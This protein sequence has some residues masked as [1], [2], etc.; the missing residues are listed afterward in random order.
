MELRNILARHEGKTLE[1]KRDDTNGDSLARTAVAFANTAGGVIVIGVAD[2][3][4]EIVGVR[5]PLEA[6]E[7]VANLLAD[8]VAPRL[9]PD[10]EILPW[11]DT[12][13]V[14]VRVHPGPSKPYRVVGEGRK[15]G[16]Y[17]RVGSTNRLADQDLVQELTRVGQGGTFDEQPLGDLAAPDAID[18]AA[19][20]AAFEGIRTVRRR[21]LESLRLATE[22]QG[23][24]VPTV[25]G[26]LLF[27]TRR[28]EHFPDAWIQCARF[29]GSG[30]SVIADSLDITSTPIE[31]ID[32]VLAF[33][34][35]SISVRAEFDGARRVEV[36]QYPPA[37]LREAVV[38]A[39]VHADYSQRGGPLKLAVYDDRIEIENPGLLVPGLTLEDVYEGVSKL[40]NRVLGRVFREVRLIEQW[41]SGVGRMLQACRAAGLPDPELREVGLR[42]RVTLYS[43]REGLPALDEVDRKILAALESRD[44]GLSTAQ[45]ASHVDRTPR[46]TRTRLRAL[47][48]AGLLVEIA[49]G[50]NDPQ[51]RYMIAEEPGRYTY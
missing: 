6:E 9:V 42:F 34:R 21:D 51:R 14:A 49:S 29:T 46:A 27:G 48:E 4:R 39:V 37:A 50:P 25:G 41:G 23:R 17:V 8:L 5:D 47:V 20:S 40:R 43:T 15:R 33:V 35:R 44:D 26:V 28:L 2:R 1:F 3:S 30:R 32:H 13:L 19:V 16:V 36:W 24:L 12:S 11:R 18:M 7:R 31:A 10:I 22:Y 45:V 38:N